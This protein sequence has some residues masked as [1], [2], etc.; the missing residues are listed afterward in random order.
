MP[1]R[2]P[3]FLTAARPTPGFSPRALLAWIFQRDALRRSRLRLAELDEHL[4]SDIGLTRT[5]AAAE[6]ARTAPAP[7]RWDAPARWHG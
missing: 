6:A 3:A 1:A 5:E 2:A 4:L 7:P